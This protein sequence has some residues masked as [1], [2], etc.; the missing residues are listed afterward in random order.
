MDKNI[1]FHRKMLWLSTQSL[2]YSSHNFDLCKNL[3]TKLGDVITKQANWCFLQQ[4]P[5]ENFKLISFAET[6]NVEH[7]WVWFNPQHSADIN[8]RNWK[9]DKSRK[10]QSGSSWR[11]CWGRFL[12]KTSFLTLPATHTR[13]LYNYFYQLNSQPLFCRWFCW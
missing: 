2:L 11:L 1:N 12:Y 6:L 13:I 3:V 5:R 7:T 4:T 10:L 9:A 8:G